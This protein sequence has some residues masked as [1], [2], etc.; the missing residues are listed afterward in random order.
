MTKYTINKTKKEMTAKK[1][2]TN[3]TKSKIDLKFGMHKQWGFFFKGSTVI[4]TSSIG[5]KQ[6]LI[7]INQN[8]DENDK[9]NIKQT[10]MIQCSIQIVDKKSRMYYAALC[11]GKLI[12]KSLDDKVEA[13]EIYTDL[14]EYVPIIYTLPIEYRE[15][16]EPLLRAIN[17]KR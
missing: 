9:N 17:K 3:K 10:G 14:K 16:F 6:I 8:Y 5:D 15:F 13:K 4:G 11:D 12:E 7:F 2:E 1:S